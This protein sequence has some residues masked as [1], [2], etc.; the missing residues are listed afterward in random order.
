MGGILQLIVVV[1]HGVPLTGGLGPAAL[2]LTPLPLVEGLVDGAFLGKAGVPHLEVGLRG[3]VFWV[4]LEEVLVAALDDV[5]VREV[6]C[7]HNAVMRPHVGAGTG[8]PL[9]GELAVKDDAGALGGGLKEAAPE[10][11]LG[12]DIDGVVDVAGFVL[13]PEAAV[14]NHQA[15]E[16]LGELA[17]HD[18]HQ[19]LRGDALDGVG[20]LVDGEDVGGGGV[21]NVGVGDGA[22]PPDLGDGNL[23]LLAV[24]DGVSPREH[25]LGGLA[26]GA[27][28]RDIE[29]G[30]VV[31]GR[32]PELEGDPVVI[33]V[34]VRGG[35]GDQG[36]GRGEAGEDGGVC[37]ERGGVFDRGEEGRLEGN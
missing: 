32:G 31:G 13:V 29:G 20:G 25:Q 9:G 33:A 3:A 2:A 11:T 23:D 12:V 7:I 27:Q 1:V 22:R 15:I 4:L 36:G 26:E 6:D 19:G 21:D 10:G 24:L 18:L 17:R 5:D 35:R 34:L 30:D 37:Q 8:G 28:V 16:M 14:H